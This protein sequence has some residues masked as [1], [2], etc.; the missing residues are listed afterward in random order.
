MFLQ[1]GLRRHLQ[2]LAVLCWVSVTATCNGATPSSEGFA[3]TWV[4][5]LGDRNFIV[6]TLENKRG[7]Y[8]GT[9][10]RPEH[11]ETS[12]GIGFSNIGRSGTQE[13]FVSANLKDD[14]LLFV[15]EKPDEGEDERSEYDMTL[16][17]KDQASIRIQGV[18]IEAWSFTRAG[19]SV[20]PTVASDW[21]PQANYP[22][23]TE[24]ISSAEMK[25]IYEDDQE[26]RQDPASMSEERWAVVGREDEQR[27]KRTHEL[28]AEGQLHTSEDFIRAAFIF[29]HGD[30]GN[31]YLL[32]H[33]LAMIAAAKGDASAAWIG[34]ATLDRYL[35]SIGKP[36]IY[37][38]QFKRGP[39]DV[40]TQEPFDREVIADALR[41]QL[42]VRSL[43]VQQE[44]LRWWTEQFQSAEAESN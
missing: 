38:T 40:A 19:G 43:E 22:Q 33:T 16:T 2:L 14:H 12:D 36:Q 18:P 9:L 42:G 21:D 35:Q 31:D 5:K 6:L 11:F 30:T 1:T 39:E 7:S 24:A 29:Q 28:L 27:R 13:V 34:A 26:A 8:S 4:M 3:G 25:R 15:T 10:S 17:G 32:A 23:E 41:Q 37:G 44:E 20:A